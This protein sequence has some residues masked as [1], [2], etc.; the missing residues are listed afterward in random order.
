[1]ALRVSALQWRLMLPPAK[2]LALALTI[3]AA[4]ATAQTPA[5][6][7]V[8]VASTITATAGAA[9]DANQVVCTLTPD[10]AAGKL[11]AV[12]TLA[13]SGAPIHTS[14]TTVTGPAGASVTCDIQRG[15]NSITWQ[16]TR[17]NPAPDSW[18]VSANG[19]QRSGPF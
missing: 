8:A 12:C 13:G 15:S 7:S 18:S 9:G 16:V 17:G 5:P 14:D 6:G 2:I 19:T 4:I 3:A 11:H 1:M 10:S